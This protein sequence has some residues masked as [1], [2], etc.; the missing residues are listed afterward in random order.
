MSVLAAPRRSIGLA[1][2]LLVV[3]GAAMFGTV[4]TARALGPDAPALP[5]AFA[6]LTF[7]AGVL[8]GYAVVT[9]AAARSARAAMRVL[10]VWGAAISQ[11]AFQLCF[12]T[13]VTR[14]GVAT[15]TLIAI[16]AAPIL[17]GMLTRNVSRRWVVAT[18]T[19]VGG[20]MLLVGGG[21]VR[22]GVGVAI[23]LGA[24]LSYAVYI[25]CG[26][27]IAASGVDLDTALAVVFALAAV[28]LAP[29]LLAGPWQW[30]GSSSGIALVLWLALVPTVLGY[31]CF[32]RGLRVTPAAPAATLGLIEPVVAT[33]LGVVVLGERLTPPAVV[34]AVLVLVA[35]LVLARTAGADAAVT[36]PA[37]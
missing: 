34:G 3:A 8:A 20:L 4:G 30:L 22:D 15:G 5:V 32:N 1:G 26:R 28:V 24:S 17:T 36:G 25:V 37:K 16:G 27:A 10:G 13:A 29:A 11:A 31:H 19:G 2:P 14:I 9:G 21:D 7:G 12:L 6:R 18:A 33:V 35:V 23:A